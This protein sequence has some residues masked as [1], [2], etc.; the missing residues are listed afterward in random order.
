VTREYRKSTTWQERS[1]GGHVATMNTMYEMLLG[2]DIWGTFFVDTWF[3][4]FKIYSTTFRT[5]KDKALSFF[6]F[7]FCKRKGQFYDQLNNT[8][9]HKQGV[10]HMDNKLSCDEVNKIY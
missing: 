10:Q 3:S 7:F 5:L 1:V 9:Q 6:S 4:L 2:D 8:I